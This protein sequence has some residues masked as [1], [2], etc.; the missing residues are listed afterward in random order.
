MTLQHGGSISNP[1]FADRGRKRGGKQMDDLYKRAASTNKTFHVVEG[2]NHMSLYDVP[3]YVDEG[4]SVVA[5][6]K[7]I[8][9]NARQSMAFR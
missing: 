5:P 3:K 2:P 1:A 8:F 4:V 9:V 7:S 6:F